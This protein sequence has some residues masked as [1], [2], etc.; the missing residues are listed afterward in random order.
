MCEGFCYHLLRPRDAEGTGGRDQPQGPAVTRRLRGG[1]E[2]GEAAGPGG[3]VH[4]P[5]A[6]VRR[7]CGWA[8]G[9]VRTLRSR[10]AGPG[11]EVPHGPAPSYEERPGPHPSACEAALTAGGALRPL[12][13]AQ[14]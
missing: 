3:R 13:T 5:A 12:S 4:G 14:L 9:T 7:L 2:R 1:P 8:A 6:A 10:D 11:A